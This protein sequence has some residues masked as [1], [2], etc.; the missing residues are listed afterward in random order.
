MCGIA[1][2]IGPDAGRVLERMLPCIAHRGPDDH[3]IFVSASGT[4]ALGHRRLSIIDPSPLGHQPMRSADGRYQIVYNGE[5]YNFAEIRPELEALGHRFVSHSD[6]EV[7][8]AAYAQWGPASLARLRGMFALA[9][10]DEREGE[11]F[12]ARDRFGIKPLYIHGDPAAGTFLFASEIKAMLGSGI[13]AR[14]AD[15]QGIWDF[16]SHGAVAQPRTIVRGVQALLPAHWMRVTRDGK[17]ETRRWWDLEEATRERRA[18][19]APEY[20]DAVRQVREKLDE[21]TRLHLIADV[22]VGA[23]LSGGIDS[24]AVVGLMSRLVHHPIRTYAVGFEARHAEM[25]ELRWARLAAERFGA[26]HTEVVMTG[27]DAARHFDELLDALDQPSLDGT[28]T[29]FVSRATRQGVTVS[30]SGLGGDELFAGYPPF[31]SYA[32]S[33]RL[34]P[35]GVP[36]LGELVG[37]TGTMIP[38][39]WRIPLQF[40]AAPPVERLSQVRRLMTEAEKTAATTSAFRDGVTLQPPQ[41]RLAALMRRGLD[42]VAQV[43]YVE[44]NDYLRNTLL[45]DADAMSMAHALEVR[46]VLLD[47]EL[48]ELAFALPADYKLQGKRSKRI[49]IDALDGLLPREI[50]ERKKMGFEL[51]VGHWLQTVLND[52]ARAAVSSPAARALFTEQFR[53]DLLAQVTRERARSARLWAFVVLLAFLD[54]HQLAVGA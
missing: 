40:M 15:P 31:R 33:A 20:A 36:G 21:A 11:L 50:V 13:V 10:W 42:P 52:R 49:F 9:I 54:R 6:T 34:A 37:A 26:E 12:L 30:L 32:R 48:A 3:G 7:V 24:T 8:L 44:L 43:S 22:P 1:G 5:V 25:D 45:R 19:P 38:G 17:T 28:N 29:W 14:E 27:E 4:V 35:A 18:A 47:H 39:R 2:C 53:G 41:A 46:P 16:L 51:P 23:F